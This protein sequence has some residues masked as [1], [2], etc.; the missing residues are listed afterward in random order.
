VKVKGPTDPRSNDL[1]CTSF[2]SRSA[3]QKDFFAVTRDWRA[4]PG[5]KT[6]P[7]DASPTVLVK[8]ISEGASRSGCSLDILS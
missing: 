1:S 5:A 4:L 2:G 3:P 8:M 7:E 6:G